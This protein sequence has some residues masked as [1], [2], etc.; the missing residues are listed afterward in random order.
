L[1]AAGIAVS[2]Q[3]CVEGNWSSASGEQAC[4]QLLGSFPD[5]DAVFIA[6]DQMAL[7]A[8]RIASRRGI[9][10]LIDCQ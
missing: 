8:L 10:N 2:D 9:T 3:H 7:G 1:N 4:I 5:M 6:N